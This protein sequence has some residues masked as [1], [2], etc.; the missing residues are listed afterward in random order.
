MTMLDRTC[1][2][3]DLHLAESPSRPRLGAFWMD[4]IFFL[5]KNFPTYPLERFNKSHRIHVW[6]IYLHYIWLIFMVNVDKYIMH[7]LFWYCFMDP[8]WVCVISKCSVP[9]NQRISE[10]SNIPPGT[11]PKPEKPAVYDS[12]FL[13]FGG[14][15]RPGVCS[16]GYVGVFLDPGILLDIQSYLLR[17]RCFRYPSSSSS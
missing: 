2:R 13:S 17:N 1:I 10:F 3:Q 16:R 4:G 12:E 14:S 5:S 15:G 6:Y 7:G 8:L 11:Y 9:R